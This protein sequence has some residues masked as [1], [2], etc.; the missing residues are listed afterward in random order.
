MVRL[1]RL[2][3]ELE[4]LPLECWS[5][6]CSEVS[7]HL[8]TKAITLR[9]EEPFDGEIGTAVMLKVDYIVVFSGV[10]FGPPFWFSPTRALI[11]WWIQHFESLTRVD[12]RLYLLYLR[13]T[14]C[15]F[16]RQQEERLSKI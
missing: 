6:T 14:E 4:A 9:V 10:V 8:T 16:K 7:I 12:D 15:Q 13:V 5:F 3:A 11:R 2:I 1:R